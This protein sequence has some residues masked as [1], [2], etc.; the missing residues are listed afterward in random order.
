MIRTLLMY[1]VVD[2]CLDKIFDP[3]VSM[4]AGIAVPCLKIGDRLSWIEFSDGTN[5][6]RVEKAIVTYMCPDRNSIIVHR[7]RMG[8]T[9]VMNRSTGWRGMSATHLRGN[10]DTVIWEKA[11]CKWESVE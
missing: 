10:L 1:L 9:Y 6:W 4:F 5:R 11:V 3:I 7:H 2:V 8:A